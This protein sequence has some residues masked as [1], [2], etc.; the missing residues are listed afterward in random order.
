M[1]EGLRHERGSQMP[2][3]GFR[4]R[5][6]HGHCPIQGT[7]GPLFSAL[8]P[9]RAQRVPLI[10]ED[11]FASNKAA[12]CTTIWSAVAR[13]RFC[14]LFFFGEWAPRKTKDQ[15]QKRCRATAL[16]NSRSCG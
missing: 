3:D 15:K 16:Q 7:P 12:R 11:F 8:C 14:F 5:S 9:E 1:L 6:C 13:H 2:E 10:F 4:L